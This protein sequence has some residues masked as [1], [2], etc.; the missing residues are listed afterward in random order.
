MQVGWPMRMPLDAR[1]VLLL[2]NKSVIT[3]L[4]Q[5]Q[6]KSRVPHRRVQTRL[7][8]LRGPLRLLTSQ[9]QWQREIENAVAR[10]K[11]ALSV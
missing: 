11:N 4:M 1:F 8:P 9:P 5:G 3:D 10:S 2:R 7:H 6:L